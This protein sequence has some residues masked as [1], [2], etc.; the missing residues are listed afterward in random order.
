MYDKFFLRAGIWPKKQDMPIQ[1]QVLQPEKPSGGM[2][3]FVLHI[4]ATKEKSNLLSRAVALCFILR[5]PFRRYLPGSFCQIW[6]F[7]KI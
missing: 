2:A 3:Y 4:A 5:K 7:L 1:M 6:L